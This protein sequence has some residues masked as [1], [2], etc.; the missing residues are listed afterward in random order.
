MT[1]NYS[2]DHSTFRSL[3]DDALRKIPT[4]SRGNWTLHAPVD[5]G[6]SLVELFAWLLEQ[7]SFWAD[8]I[9]APLVRAVMALFGD[10]MRTA[11]PAGTAITFAPELE[12]DSSRAFAP[13]AQLSRRTPVRIPET[14]TRSSVSRQRLEFTPIPL[15]ST[16]LWVKMSSGCV[17]AVF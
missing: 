9:T 17:V 2:I 4:A 13:H 3:V 8:Q 11:V 10:A 5:P 7:R 6:I 16:S 15:F 14:C 1:I 12:L